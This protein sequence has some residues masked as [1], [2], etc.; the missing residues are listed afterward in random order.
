MDFETTQ[1]LY[2]EA[3]IGKYYKAC[4][5]DK[6]KTM[7][8][9][10]YNLRLCQRFYGVLNIFEVILRNAVNRHY[11]NNFA[12]T[13]WITDQAAN[14][15]LLTNYRDEIKQTEADYKKRGVYNNDK[16]VSSSRLFYIYSW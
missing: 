11:Q 10:R 4:D 8:L 6:L 15:K 1:K 14:G 5:G 13:E 2:S 3:R 9:Y 7:Q 16:M 12:D